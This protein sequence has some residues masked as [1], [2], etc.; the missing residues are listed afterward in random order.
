MCR[1]EYVFFH[2]KLMFL[3]LSEKTCLSIKSTD[4][5]AELCDGG[6]LAVVLTTLPRCPISRLVKVTAAEPK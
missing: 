3:L 2:I 5:E 4:P 1:E 6:A